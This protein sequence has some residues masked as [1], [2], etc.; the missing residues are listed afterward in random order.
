MMNQ[1]HFLRGNRL[2]KPS[3]IRGLCHGVYQIIHI[4][5]LN[6]AMNISM[7]MELVH[8]N[9][10]RSFQ[11]QHCEC[12]HSQYEWYIIFW[13]CSIGN[14]L[15]KI[16]CF[17]ELLWKLGEMVTPGLWIWSQGRGLEVLKCLEMS[18]RFW[19]I[20]RSCFESKQ[21]KRDSYGS[22]DSCSLQ[23]W[24]WEKCQVPKKKK[25][26]QAHAGSN[27]EQPWVVQLG[28]EA[29]GKL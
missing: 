22:C 3:K 11:C 19:Y 28:Q 23:W 5:N 7:R 13:N 12:S 9:A 14:I 8:E 15:I 27:R 18:W 10:T 24:S 20:L 21:N 6:T 16:W 1:P 25:S 29:R 26:K 2:Y 17:K 4:G